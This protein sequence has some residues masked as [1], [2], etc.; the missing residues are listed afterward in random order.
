MRA[1]AREE[2]KVKLQYRDLTGIYPPSRYVGPKQMKEID[3]AR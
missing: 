3:Y 2:L 1:E